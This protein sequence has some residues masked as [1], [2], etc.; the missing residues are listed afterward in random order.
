MVKI[1]P[2]VNEN[3]RIRY[4]II[5]ELY[6]E[7][8]HGTFPELEKKYNKTKDSRLM[9]SAACDAQ[10]LVDKN[11]FAFLDRWLDSTKGMQAKFDDYSQRI[12]RQMLKPEKRLKSFPLMYSYTWLI[13]QLPKENIVALRARQKYVREL[14]ALE[15]KDLKANMDEEDED[16]MAEYIDRQMNRPD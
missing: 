2:E 9:L 4:A 6:I 13:Y 16:E 14:S 7:Q 12:M 3:Q 10:S 11:G 15:Q 8:K 5:I 1:Y